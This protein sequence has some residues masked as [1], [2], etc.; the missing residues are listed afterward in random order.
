MTTRLLAVAH[1]VTLTG[2]PMN[3]LHLLRWLRAHEDV[4][5]HT[6]VVRDGPLRHRFEEVG[7][8]TLLD[9][10]VV[11]ELLGTL[12]VGLEHLGSRRAWKPVAAARLIPQLR[13]LDDFDLV[14]CNSLTSASMLRHLPASGAVVAHAHELEVAYRLWRAEHE[15]SLFRTRPDRWIAASGA[16]RDLLVGEVGLPPDRVSVHHEFIDVGQVDGRA[17]GLREVERCRRELRIPTDAAVV[18]GAG[19]V[20]W[21]KGP[22]L[23]VQLACEVRRRTREPVHFVWVGGDLRSP[24]WERVRSDRDRAGAD[25]VHFVGVKPD[26]L[27][28][29]AMADVFALTSREDPFP[30]VCLEA[31][32]L[33][34][35]IVTYR[36][37]GMPE[38]LEAAG[39]EAA[40]GIVDHLDVGALAER[41]LALVDSD[42][43]RAVAGAS[44]R[45]RVRA[46]HD[47]TVAAPRLWADLAPLAGHRG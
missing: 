33:G 15:V 31:A 40:H 17:V 24:D 19:T 3:L 34:V 16:V 39:A 38:L 2:A 5:V 13:G 18:V 11:P 41:T 23:F 8:V 30:L 36:N 6:L 25:H 42:A 22:D 12:Q 1:E 4:E 27:P 37:G 14:Y 26:P 21:R 44:L 45:E 32:A 20:D 43:L 46:E 7:G 28:W 35:P 10:W 47:V 29:F 9:R